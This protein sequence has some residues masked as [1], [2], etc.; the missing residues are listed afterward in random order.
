[1]LEIKKT[2][3]QKQT[4]QTAWRIKAVLNLVTQETEE[5]DLEYNLET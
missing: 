2:E 3:F 5:Q 4:K 1:M